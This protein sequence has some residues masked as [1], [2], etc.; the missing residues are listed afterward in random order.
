MTD[1]N[2][3]DAQD[4]HL[5]HDMVAAA[6][7]DVLFESASRRLRDETGDKDLSCA[8][9]L[10]RLGRAACEAV[11]ADVATDEL[12]SALDARLHRVPMV[13]VTPADECVLS[14]TG[15][16]RES[17]PKHTSSLHAP[18]VGNA[19][20]F[21]GEEGSYE[22]QH[23]VVCIGTSLDGWCYDD[24]CK[25]WYMRECWLRDD[26]VLLEDSFTKVTTPRFTLDTRGGVERRI[27]T[28]IGFSDFAKLIDPTWRDLLCGDE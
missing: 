23:R 20:E 24:T 14:L 5:D 7:A 26:G 16:L 21:L 4:R 19:W 1:N 11:A 28:E 22:R 10:A 17:D 2:P 15:M 12:V 3:Q 9:A 27:D 25:V 13:E 6:I 18:L 8:E